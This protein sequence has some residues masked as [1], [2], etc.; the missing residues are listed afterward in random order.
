MWQRAET[1]SPKHKPGT[2]S[3]E[4]ICLTN[5]G[6]VYKLTYMGGW[7]RPASFL[8]GEVV[9]WWIENPQSTN[10]SDA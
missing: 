10:A 9:E 1:E 8:K 3:A 4:M 6:N 5:L 7:Q 2:W